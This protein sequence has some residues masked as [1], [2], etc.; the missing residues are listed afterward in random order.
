MSIEE[1]KTTYGKLWTLLC[2]YPELLAQKDVEY[3]RF[4][5]NYSSPRYRIFILTTP[6]SEAGRPTVP[7][8][9]TGRLTV[10]GSGSEAADRAGERG[11]AAH[12]TSERGGAA[13]GAGER[14]GAADGA[15]E[16]GGAADQARDH[17]C[18]CCTAVPGPLP[19]AVW[20]VERDHPVPQASGDL[21]CDQH[22]GGFEGH[23]AI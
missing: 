3:W 21:G 17:S 22:G 19:A 1:K 15:G 9:G 2:Q 8:S 4:V 11:G 20:G 16:R 23:L 5:C 7:A 14:G 10:P 13:D 12:R 18:R 6:G